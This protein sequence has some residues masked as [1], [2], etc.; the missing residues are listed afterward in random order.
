ML[1][2][3]IAEGCC[4]KPMEVIPNTMTERLKMERI[5]AAE[6]L[7][8]IEDALALLSKNPDMQNL[9]DALSD[10]RIY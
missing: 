5:K 7:Q 10:L 2:Q 8:K 3:V 1:N 4:E 6:R 9:L